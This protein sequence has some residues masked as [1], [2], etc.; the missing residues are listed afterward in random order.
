MFKIHF[1]DTQPTGL[2]GK[3]SINLEGMC[4]RGKRVCVKFGVCV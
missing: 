3:C 1:L 4:E 2:I